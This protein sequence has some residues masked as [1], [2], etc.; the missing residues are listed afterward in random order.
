MLQYELHHDGEAEAGGDRDRQ[1]CQHQGECSKDDIQSLMQWVPNKAIESVK[2]LD[3]VMNEMELP[4]PS[5][6]MADV[7][8]KSHYAIG[9]QQREQ[10]LNHDWEPLRPEVPSRQ[11]E[12][13]QQQS[14]QSE[15][16]GELVDKA[17][18]HVL[19]NVIMRPVPVF[20]VWKHSLDQ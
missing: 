14:A 4:Q 6:T 1:A 2:A 3:T 10:K 8:N 13:D 11:L 19:A 17:M 5:H 12:T 15:D 20:F 18:S 16:V 7:M 9:D